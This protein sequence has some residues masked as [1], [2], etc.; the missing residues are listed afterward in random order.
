[1]EDDLWLALTVPLLGQHWHMVWCL[2]ILSMPRDK[3]GTGDQSMVRQRGRSSPERVKYY[4]Q[5][6]GQQIMSGISWGIQHPD[7]HGVYYSPGPI[8]PPSIIW[9]PKDRGQAEL[10][11]IGPL[12]NFADSRIS[13]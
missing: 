6:R 9:G 13:E 1:M 11:M 4:P 10:T 5:R 2:L 3:I 12:L 7:P 8:R